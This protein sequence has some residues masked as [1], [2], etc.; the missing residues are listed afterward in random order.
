MNLCAEASVV[1]FLMYFFFV[2]S[3]CQHIASS[4][5]TKFVKALSATVE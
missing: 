4:N 1:F 2:I 3:D 5:K